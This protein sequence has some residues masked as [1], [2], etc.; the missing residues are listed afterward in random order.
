MKC[1]SITH[2]FL[3]RVHHSSRGIIQ[4]AAKIRGKK[5]HVV[6]VALKVLQEQ[7]QSVFIEALT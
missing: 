1:Y 6:F 4:K 5:S 7:E 3:L 2:I